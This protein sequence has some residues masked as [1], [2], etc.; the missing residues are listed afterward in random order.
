MAHFAID[1]RLIEFHILVI[2]SPAF[3]ISQPAGMAHR[4]NCL[5]AGRAIELF[6]GARVSTLAAR[7]VDYL[8]EVDPLFVQ[9]V[10]L[11][12]KYVDFAVGKFR[13]ICLLEFRSNR[14]IDRIAVPLAVSLKDFEIMPALTE[15]LEK[16][17][18]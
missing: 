12:R 1:T 14:V 7:A 9:Q 16:A 2:K 10:V 18:S 15:A 3:C 5:I 8:P 17:K 6:P 4:A 11:D 13:G